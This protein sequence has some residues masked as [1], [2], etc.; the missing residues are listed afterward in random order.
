MNTIY[1]FVRKHGAIGEFYLRGIT[2]E[3][4]KEQ[5][6]TDLYWVDLFHKAGY[7]VRTLSPMKI[8]K[9]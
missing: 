5:L 9:V 8:K 1:A 2:S 6:E 7:E 3:L 4:S